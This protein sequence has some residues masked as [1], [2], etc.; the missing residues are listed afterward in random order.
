MVYYKSIRATLDADFLQTIN[1]TNHTRGK[2]V[3]IWNSS[4]CTCLL[5]IHSV[6]ASLCSCVKLFSIANMLLVHYAN[7][8]FNRLFRKT[9]E[10][11]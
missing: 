11:K 2:V 8:V 3:A 4:T 1:I 7:S 9:S 6:E 5:V 10:G